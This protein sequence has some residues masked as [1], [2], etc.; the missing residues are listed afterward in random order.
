MVAAHIMCLF[1]FLHIIFTFSPLLGPGGEGLGR[2]GMGWRGGGSPEGPGCVQ[3]EVFAVRAVCR[4]VAGSE[5]T[6]SAAGEKGKGARGVP[7]MKEVGG[8]A[9]NSPHPASTGRAAC[10]GDLPAGTASHLPGKNGL[11]GKGPRD[12]DPH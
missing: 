8:K 5:L 2:A 7:Q 12:R 4:R 6:L 3:E 9:D 1:C 11:G 10:H